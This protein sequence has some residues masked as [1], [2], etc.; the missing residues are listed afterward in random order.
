[1]A[2]PEVVV[3]GA[4]LAGCEAALQLAARGVP[5]RL[6]EMRPLVPTA[7]HRTADVAELVCSNSLKGTTPGSAANGIKDELACMGS[8]LLQAARKTAIPAGGALAVDRERFSAAVQELLDAN[9]LI[10]IERAECT[11]IPAGP[12]IIA[13]GPLTSD[14]L[15]AELARELLLRHSPSFSFFFDPIVHSPPRFQAL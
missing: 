2:F 7:V 12:A 5:V 11:S 8:Y 6:M 13:T 4:G 3:A 10:R 14:A 1:M 15:A 9:P